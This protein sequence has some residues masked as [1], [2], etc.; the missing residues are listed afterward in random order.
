[1]KHKVDIYLVLVDCFDPA[2][3]TGGGTCKDGV[4]PFLLITV[5]Y[6][7]IARQVGSSKKALDVIKFVV[8]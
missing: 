3:V 6:F 2:L 7:Q 4:K 5:V 1:M 8:V